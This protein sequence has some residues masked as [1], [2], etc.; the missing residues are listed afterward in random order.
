MK[1]IDIHT[2]LIPE[3]LPDWAGK[4][5]Y[6]GFVN[7]RHCAPGCAQMYVDDRFFREIQSNCWDPRHRIRDCDASGVQ[8]QVLSTIPVLFSY[9]AKPS[10]GLD[11]SRFLNDHLADVVRQ[12]PDR[13]V[14]LGTLP[15]QDPGLAIGEMQRCMDELGFGGFEIGSHI[16][17][18]NLD[19]P[20]L[21]AFFAEAEACGAA[22]FVHPWDMLGSERMPK[23]WLPWLV[24]MPAETSLSICCMLFGGVF[25]RYPD[26][27]VAFA[28]GG[29]AFPGTYGRIRHGFAAR[30]DLVAVDNPVS[31]DE[32]LGKFWVDALVHDQ[33]MLDKIIALFGIDRVAMGSDYPFP[34]GE[35]HP[36]QLIEESAYDAD[37][38]SWLLY[39]SAEAWLGIL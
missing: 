6:G 11:L 38:K 5:G 18:W 3:K 14:G 20:E 24:G 33:D 9:W 23:Y 22:L 37:E 35:A 30:P 10:D 19:A 34:L 13:F 36:G 26:L 17:H 4:F 16:N 28:H 2:H 27:R 31:P 15:M 7:L 32:A 21:N 39:R 29:G 1:K 25:E 8:I 12:Y